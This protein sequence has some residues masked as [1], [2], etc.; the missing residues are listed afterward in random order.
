[1]FRSI[2]WIIVLGFPA[3]SAN[4]DTTEKIEFFE[5]RIR[6]ILAQECYECHSEETK[7]KGGLYL[8]TRAGW[9]VGGDSGESVIVPG[10]PEESLLLKSIAHDIDDLQMPKAGAKLEESVLA[11]FRKWIADGA[12]DPRTA[13]PRYHRTS[14][15]RG[16]AISISKPC[17]KPTWRRPRA[18]SRAAST[19]S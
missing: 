3:G 19:C 18:C 2:K 14:M 1:M 13:P 6:P 16:S 9:E 7:D 10:K 4:A 11:D 5:S 17:G 8:D 12:V 15:T